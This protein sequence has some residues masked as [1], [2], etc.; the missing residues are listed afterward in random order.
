MRRN[1]RNRI[2][3]NQTS[4]KHQFVSNKLFV[5]RI[6]VAYSDQISQRKC[7]EQTLGNI[8]KAWKSWADAQ[9]F[10]EILSSHC[11]LCLCNWKHDL[12][13]Q[14]D[15]QCSTCSTFEFLGTTLLRSCAAPHQSHLTRDNKFGSI[16]LSNWDREEFKWK[17]IRCFIDGGIGSYFILRRCG[18]HSILSFVYKRI[19]LPVSLRGNHFFIDAVK[20]YLTVSTVTFKLRH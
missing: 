16:R 6:I 2:K 8:Q 5:I 4:L 12:S 14:G 13:L 19:A 10:C 3:V 15:F 1:L 9:I 20:Y 7:L 11:G 17:A 18:M